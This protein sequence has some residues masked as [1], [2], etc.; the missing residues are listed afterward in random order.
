MLTKLLINSLDDGRRKKKRA[1]QEEDHSSKELQ[2]KLKK[3]KATQANILLDIKRSA[4]HINQ[5]KNNLKIKK[6]FSNWEA[7]EKKISSNDRQAAQKELAE[8]KTFELN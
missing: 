2:E 4:F 6:H 3:K 1:L 8:G 7:F 5:L